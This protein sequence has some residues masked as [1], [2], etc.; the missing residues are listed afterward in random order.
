MRQL[1]LGRW[2]VLVLGVLTV[3]G[4]VALTL[5]PRI[6]SGPAAAAAV[7]VDGF[8]T[9]PGNLDNYLDFTFGSGN[10][11]IS[12]KSSGSGAADQV[13]VLNGVDLTLGTS[14][15]NDVIS[16]MLAAGRLIIN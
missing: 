14:S 16:M 5:V 4:V 8:G 2:P 15:D 13:I 6:V 12:V 3:L 11:T 7:A 9:N 10:T 1:V